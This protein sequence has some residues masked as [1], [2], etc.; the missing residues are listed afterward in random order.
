MFTK[1]RPKTADSA[2][3]IRSQASASEQP[4][5]TAGP[6]TAATTGF[7]QLADALDDRVVALAQHLAD[8]RDLLP[9]RRRCSS[10]SLRSAPEENPRPAPVISTARTDGSAASVEDRLAQLV[11][12]LVVPGVQPLRPVERDLGDA[13]LDAAGRRSRRAL[14]LL[15]SGDGEE[16]TCR[17]GLTDADASM[18]STGSSGSVMPAF[19]SRRRRAWRL[20]RSLPRA[21]RARRPTLILITH[22]H[23]D[24]FSRDDVAAARGRRHAAG[25]ARPRS[26]SS[27]AART[28]R[29]RPARRSRSAGSR[30]RRCRRLQHEQA[31]QRGPAVP[32]RARRAGSAT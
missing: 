11:A 15:G 18:D 7:G 28:S 27:C 16:H 30:S 22:D 14:R 31:R 12:E 1:A 10:I 13:V 17:H 20:H 32:L 4:I 8:V 5:P 3:Q 26:P 24:H 25:R 2:A 29:S 23:F 9:A 6:L 19:A 21:A